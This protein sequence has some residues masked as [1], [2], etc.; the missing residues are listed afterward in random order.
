MTETVKNKTSNK[1]LIII[2]AV[3]V[4]AALAIAVPYKMNADKKAAIAAQE[5]EEEKSASAIEEKIDAI[6]T[7][8]LGSEPAITNA[9]SAYDGAEKAVQGKVGNYATLTKAEEDYSALAAQEEADIAAAGNVDSLIAAIGEVTLNSGDAITAARTGYDALNE[10]AKGK[11]T[12][13]ETLQ[14]AEAT[15]LTA[16]AE[17][18]ARIEKEQAEALARQQAEAAA[19]AAQSASS[20]GSNSAKAKSGSS[21]SNTSAKSGTSGSNGTGSSASSG[22]SAGGASSGSGNA[23]AWTPEREAAAN[24][25]STET[26]GR[27]SVISSPDDIK[28][29]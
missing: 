18:Q 22:S 15:F 14:L 24:K 4:A 3:V 10:N 25:A 19:K 2:G 1:K 20:S 9:R 6:G 21:K 8:T 13:Y 27:P 26:F 5:A 16:Q 11:V 23:D 17:E 12:N 29:D 7:V 28:W